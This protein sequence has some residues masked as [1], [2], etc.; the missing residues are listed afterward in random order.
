MIAV[1]G[2]AFGFTTSATANL[3]EKNDYW[4][5]TVGGFPCGAIVGL[6]CTVPSALRLAILLQEP[7]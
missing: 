6:A 1:A 5:E 4:N 7:Y 2:G 3:R